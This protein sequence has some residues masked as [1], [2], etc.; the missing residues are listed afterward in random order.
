MKVGMHFYSPTASEIMDLDLHRQHREDRRLPGVAQ[1]VGQL[2][3]FPMCCQVS[4]LADYFSTIV[5]CTRG[6]SIVEK[7]CSLPRLC[8]ILC[9]PVLAFQY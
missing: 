5:Y 8:H 6:L 7:L 3:L 9:T 2:A 1:G 4:C